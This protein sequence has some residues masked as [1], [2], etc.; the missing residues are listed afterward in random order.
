MIPS[1]AY[2]CIYCIFIYSFVIRDFNGNDPVMIAWM[3]TGNEFTVIKKRIKIFWFLF[4]YLVQVVKYIFINTA[5]GINDLLTH[6]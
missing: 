1:N 5:K 3:Q 4:M 2:I 6:T